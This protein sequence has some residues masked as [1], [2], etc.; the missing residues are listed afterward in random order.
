MPIPMPSSAAQ[1][2][3]VVGHMGTRPL[4]LIQRAGGG[5]P[6]PPLPPA[7]GVAAG[8]VPPPPPLP[9]PPPAPAVVVAPA[10]PAVY[11]A[12][13][14]LRARVTAAMAAAALPHPAQVG[15][16]ALAFHPPTP[17]APWAY[18]RTVQFNLVLAPGG[19]RTVR[20]HIHYTPVGGGFVAGPGRYWISGHAGW[21]AQTP[22]WVVAANNVPPNLHARTA[23]VLNFN[24][25]H[26]GN[27]AVI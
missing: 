3:Y 7:G 6:L 26:G 11:V 4:N 27:H 14:V 17:L 22:N 10:A 21:D 24:L 18:T 23:A 1:R 20:A 15:A 8:V 16:G 2:S 12:P 19:A 13:G 9:P 25:R 5:V